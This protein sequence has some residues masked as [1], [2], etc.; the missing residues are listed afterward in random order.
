MSILRINKIEFKNFKFFRKEYPIVL[1]GKNLL[2][3]G[4]NGSGK[5][6]IYWGLYT[7]LQSSIK[8]ATPTDGGKYFAATH[9]ESL[10]NTHADSSEDSYIRVEF[11]DPGNDNTYGRE[12]SRGNINT[13]ESNGFLVVYSLFLSDF[14]NFNQL[15]QIHGFRNSEVC[16]LSKIFLHDIFP[17]ILFSNPYVNLDGV[18]VH[19]KS[20]ADW[21][22]YICDAKDMLPLR[23]G[24]NGLNRHSTQYTRYI[25]L[26][27]KFND[28]LTGYLQSIERATNEILREKYKII[29][30]VKLN[31]EHRAQFDYYV[32]K[33]PTSRRS[34]CRNLDTPKIVLRTEIA[35]PTNP[36]GKRII[37]HLSSYYNE[38]KLTLIS[39]S[40]RLAILKTKYVV[41]PALVT[42]ATDHACPIVCVDDIMTSMDMSNRVLVAEAI[43]S[44]AD[45]Y[46]MFIFTH[47]IALYDLF[48]NCIAENRTT[49]KWIMNKMYRVDNEDI[50]GVNGTPYP[51]VC[52][53]KTFLEQA[54]IQYSHFEYP[55]CASFLRKYVENLLK[56]IYPYNMQLEIKPDNSVGIA[57][58][59][60]LIAR[61]RK[62]YD[63]YQLPVLF[64]HVDF[65]R[66]HILNP[67]SHDDF[68]APA[69]KL[70]MQRII[71]ELENY[72][73][74]LERRVI[75]D[76]EDCPI[77]K[78]RLEVTV[79]SSVLYCEFAPI[80]RFDYFLYRHKDPVTASDV[81]TKHY[82]NAA[83]VVTSFCPEFVE[84]SEPTLRNC[85][86]AL[87][88][89]A[90]NIDHAW[91]SPELDTITVRISDG[92]LLSSI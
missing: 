8:D 54:K 25:S 5:S 39:L 65:Y 67:F 77:I 2:I 17:A 43:L 56:K 10:C 85:Y 15:S 12:A 82:K 90:I 74:G 44:L 19:N 38:A 20:V 75:V 47:D 49:G 13:T 71:E 24:N 31:L 80:E 36:T 69:Y 66:Q 68:Q 88:H 45:K 52:T 50:I 23:S 9:P 14:I 6:S 86:E 21:W 79:S 26:I 42:S 37:E 72:N 1:R 33:S 70:E 78:F 32:S 61:L 59:S 4:E 27:G 30:K 87:M 73:D 46:Q 84:P 58:L 7:F 16:D 63:L 28:E 55:S 89:A 3:Y 83:V 91:V 57:D 35:D 53:N 48:E 76:P 40:L 41:P 60:K 22:K 64:P 51:I 62:F 11:I 92:M 34:R 18:E 29:D 81:I